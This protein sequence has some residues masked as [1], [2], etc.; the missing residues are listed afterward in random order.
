MCSACAMPVRQGFKLL[1][2][3]RQLVT[4]RRVGKAVNRE[5]A[6]V[7]G[8]NTVLLIPWHQDTHMGMLTHEGPYT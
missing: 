5:N 8:G 4:G 7:W 3:Y 1:M 6:W 2:V